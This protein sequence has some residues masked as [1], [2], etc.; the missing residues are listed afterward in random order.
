MRRRLGVFIFLILVLS[1]SLIS[2]VWWNPWTWFEEEKFSPIVG[3]SS[4][5]IRLND[6][7]YNVSAMTFDSTHTRVIVND[8]SFNLYDKQRIAPY[9]LSYYSGTAKYK[10]L[11]II[12]RDTFFEGYVGGTQNTSLIL[13]FVKNIS[14]E[15]SNLNITFNGKKYDIEIFP[16]SGHQVSLRINGYRSG[17]ISDFPFTQENPP[18]YFYPHRGTAKYNNLELILT[19]IIYEAY[20]GGTHN[21][22]VILAFNVN[23]SNDCTENWNCSEWSECLNNQQT[24]ICNNLHPCKGI[25][26]TPAE[27]QSCSS[28][29]PPEIECYSD[30]DC[31]RESTG[32]LYCENNSLCLNS[33]TY[34]CID[35]GTTESYCKSTSA[36]N[37]LPCSDGCKNNQCVNSSTFPVSNV[38]SNIS[39]K[40]CEQIG[41][42]ENGKYCSSQYFLINQKNDD[43]LCENNFE[44]KSNVCLNTICGEKKFSYLYLIVGVV[45]LLFIFILF[46]FLIKNS[47]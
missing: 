34:R 39:Q 35:D 14:A 19:D 22:S 10:D 24:R 18:Y 28:P 21:V 16:Y 3:F 13:A 29:Q 11:N 45:I 33:V 27:I 31:A 26:N 46:Y 6:E 37:C 30:E 17:F 43:S 25:N 4:T 20:S 32:P 38:S 2:A 15:N 9:Y 41:L 8:Q 1:L 12:F 42:R 47:Q 44:C 36:K 7:E 23:L 40:E 5:N